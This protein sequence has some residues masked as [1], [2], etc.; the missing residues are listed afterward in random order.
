MTG[1]DEWINQLYPLVLQRI[2][3]GIHIV[4]KEGITLFYN[5][6]AATLDGL[7]VEE[8]TGAYIL[9]VFPS[10]NQKTSTLLQVL[11]C[12]RAI[13]HQ[14]QM[15]TN[16]YGKQIVTI[17]R[18]VPL[19]I[20]GKL[21]G[22]LEIAKDITYVKNLSEQVRQLQTEIRERG[23]K[24][25]VFMQSGAVDREPIITQSEKM[26]Q[27]LDRAQKAAQTSSP[28]LVV[29]ETGTGKE[30]I[31]QMIHRLSNERHTS[32]VVQN[33]AAIPASLLEGLL[34]GTVRGAFTGAEDRAGLFEL[35]DGGTL[36]LD[37]LHA[38]PIE[39]QAK[40]LR[41]LEEG[42]VRRVGDLKERTAR[43]RLLVA[44]NQDPEESIR[45]GQLR[46]DLY[47]RIQVVRITLPPLRERMEDLPLLTRFFISS[48]N[49]RFQKRVRGITTDVGQ[50]FQ[51]YDWPGNVR[52]LKHAVEGAMNLVEGEWIESKHLPAHIVHSPEEK[53]Q[54]T[55]SFQPLREAVQ[56]LEE[57]MIRQALQKEAG[58]I[59]K[60]AQVLEIPRQTL[61]YKMKKWGLSKE[62]S[63]D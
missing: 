41:V 58:N 57:K 34:F 10:L 35:A 29:G 6:M 56:E 39:L 31:V 40:L 36:F 37:E 53:R 25:R 38:M 24:K 21:V 48:Y 44:T 42:V 16:R 43:A 33:C 5:D 63:T 59:V 60:A 18:T 2:D 23:K 3:D 12:G 1:K 45:T 62:K 22:A 32:L 8:V 4:D 9:D 7:S 30:L 52:E 54:K 51:R 28:V 20:E 49:E 13:N 17:N 26:E 15:Y 19:Y 14:Q 47:Y 50:I 61:Q 46:S 27:A 55:L 11:D